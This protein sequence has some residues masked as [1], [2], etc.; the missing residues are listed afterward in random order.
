MGAVRY[1]LLPFCFS[2][3]RPLRSL[4]L[5]LSAEGHAMTAMDEDNLPGYPA[6]LF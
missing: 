2:Q 1:E 5:N 4:G 6:G 3:I